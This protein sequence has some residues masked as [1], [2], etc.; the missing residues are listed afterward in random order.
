MPTPRTVTPPLEERVRAEL[1][2]IRSNVVGV[3]GSLVAT[4]DGFLVAHDVPD[5]EPT[6]IAALVATTRALATRTTAAAGRG[7]FREALAR[8]SHGY[9]AAYAAG[10]NAIVAVIGTNELNVG[11]LHYQTR[12]IIERIAANSPEFRKWPSGESGRQAATRSAGA[13]AATPSSGG[14]AMTA[15]PATAT[16][17]APPASAVPL[18]RRRPLRRPPAEPPAS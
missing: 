15:R 9:L 1:E 18:P 11:M 17:A 7:E 2:L 3:H 13:R 6:E 12:E 4:S 16:A 5:L 8:G 14:R 10:T